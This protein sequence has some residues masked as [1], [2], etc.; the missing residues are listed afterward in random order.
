V[1]RTGGVGESSS[2]DMFLAFSTG[3]LPVES[4]DEQSPLTSTVSMLA[5]HRMDPLFDAVVEATEEAI[6]NALL[7]ASTMTGCD[8]VVAHALDGALLDRALTRR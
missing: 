5:H 8:G 1:A 2:G 3:A 7:A 4:D 6:V